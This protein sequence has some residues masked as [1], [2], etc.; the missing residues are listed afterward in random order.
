MIQ[1]FSAEEEAAIVEA[2]RAAEA[3]T[4]GEVRV[5]IEKNCRGDILKAAMRTF[6]KLGMHRTADRNGV[7]IFIAPERRELAIVG[8]AGIHAVA[9][10]GFWDAERDLMIEG[11]RQ[12][13][14]AKG[15]CAAIAAVGEKLKA[16]FP[17]QP[18]DN[19][20]LP[21]EISYSD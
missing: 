3:Q 7:L 1:L 6:R 15:I 20:E 21:N 11:F 9:P 12:G 5:H 2:I 8:D 16:H 17:V 4:S 19:N 13:Q 14:A 10:P 18:N